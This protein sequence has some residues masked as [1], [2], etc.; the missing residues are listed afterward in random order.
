MWHVVT[1]A[2]L[3]LGSAFAGALGFM[4]L[5]SLH[6][7]DALLNS[8]TMLAGMGMVH[9]PNTGAGKLFTAGF[10]LYAGLI[11]LAT[12]GVVLAPLVHRL[13]H[14]FHWDQQ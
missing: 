1:A 4:T 9:V 14:T 10:S 5:E 6:W 2:S 8:T 11:F 13:L 7:D 12:A 3:V